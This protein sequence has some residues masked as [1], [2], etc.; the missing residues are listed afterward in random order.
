MVI[1]LAPKVIDTPASLFKSRKRER[2]KLEGAFPAERQIADR[3]AKRRGMFETVA[4]T[5][6]G[7]DD[8]I[9]LRM[10]VNDK[11]EI[12]CDRVETLR[13]L[14]AF[15]TD[16]FDVRRYEIAPHRFDLACRHFARHLLRR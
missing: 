14:H 1:T 3:L 16:T 2:A 11:A 5:G 8:A 13:R 10:A 4:R 9:M 6:R 15:R 12:L 7:D